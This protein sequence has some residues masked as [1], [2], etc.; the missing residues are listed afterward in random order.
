MW[1]T[2]LLAIVI[3]SEKD[4]EAK[5]FQWDPTPSENQGILSTSPPAL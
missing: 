1:V 4:P 5:L 3:G 2:L